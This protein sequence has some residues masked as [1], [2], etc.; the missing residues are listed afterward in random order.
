MT[1]MMKLNKRACVSVIGGSVNLDVFH[2][3]LGMRLGPG[4][5]R[6]G[7]D[8]RTVR[9]LAVRGSRAAVALLSTAVVL[10]DLWL[11]ALRMRKTC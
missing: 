8:L 5:L 2:G 3:R 11:H 4:M 6:L 9:P 1:M 7:L 10:G